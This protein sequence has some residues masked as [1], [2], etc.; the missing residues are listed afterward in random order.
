[1]YGEGARKCNQYSNSLQAGWS[2]DQ[3]SV[4]A[5]FSTPVQTSP[6][7]HPAA[8]TVGTSSL[9]GVNWLGRGINSAPPSSVKVNERVDLYLYSLS[10]PS[11]QVT[12]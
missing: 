1:M 12:R 9:W 8:Y 11:W 3:I 2:V 4:G 10:V 5:R 7:T 6:G